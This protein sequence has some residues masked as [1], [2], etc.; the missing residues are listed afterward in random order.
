[1]YKILLVDDEPDL[2][3]ELQEG[4]EFEGFDAD[5]AGSVDAA[6]AACD[7]VG[8]DVVVTDLKMPKKGGLDLL[9]A[10]SNEAK[11]P[12]IFVLSGHGAKTNR[13]EAMTLGA[14]ECFAKPVDLDDLAD[15]IR[16]ISTRD[17]VLPQ[18]CTFVE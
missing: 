18:V 13:P 1:M 11:P 15:R 2:L 3:E 4:L 7:A 14:A 12:V 16:A 9:R 17:D 10:L 6:L 5:T 8:Y